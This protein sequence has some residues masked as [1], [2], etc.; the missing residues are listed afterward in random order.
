ML[1]STTYY[2]NDV[3]VTLSAAWEI[4]NPFHQSVTAL[5]G[6]VNMPA[7]PSEKKLYVVNLN[8]LINCRLWYECQVHGDFALCV[9]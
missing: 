1:Y 4:P 3:T 5:M 6:F 9:F 8:Q 7:L 2:L